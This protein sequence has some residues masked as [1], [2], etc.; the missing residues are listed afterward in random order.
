MSIEK[1]CVICNITQS[2]INFS[3]GRCQ[4]KECMKKKR[5]EREIKPRISNTDKM[6]CKKCDCEKSLEF[7]KNTGNI[8]KECINKQNIYSKQQRI[9]KESLLTHKQCKTCDTLKE[10]S[11]F[12]PNE[13]ICKECNKIKLYSWR[14]ENK[15]KINI[16]NTK[17]R[18]SEDYR[19]KQNTIKRKIY[20]N[21]VQEQL[22]NKYRSKLRY[23]LKSNKEIYSD[24][25]GCYNSHFKKWIEF[26]FESNMNWTNYGKVW[27]LDHIKPCSSFDLENE[28]NIKL[29][30]SWKNTIPSYIKQNLEKFNHI[31]IKLEEFI[32][33]KVIN[34]LKSGEIF[35]L[36]ETPKNL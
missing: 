31:D 26:N 15:D 9:I 18:N 36:R 23:F 28:Q 8:C 29:C 22:R 17:Y 27:N 20:N 24:I 32:E 6:K 33:K 11:N 13:F 14:K 4:C 25:F 34:F 2:I 5:R 3:K 12:R 7:F 30:F 10:I 35:K 21:N 16:I 19:E 1:K